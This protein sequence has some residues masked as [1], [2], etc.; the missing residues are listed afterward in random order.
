LIEEFRKLADSVS[1]WY[2]PP[3]QQIG[4]GLYQSIKGKLMNLP[5]V[6]V[7]AAFPPESFVTQEVAE[8]SRRRA[9]LLKAQ[10]SFADAALVG[11]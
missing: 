4:R 2:L 3:E 11:R 1:R 6:E 7:G 5:D 9:A 10:P 8:L